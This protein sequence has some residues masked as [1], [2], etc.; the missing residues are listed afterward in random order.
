M[1]DEPKPSGVLAE[2]HDLD[3]AIYQAVAATPTPK[4]DAALH[5]LT[6]FADNSKL[7]F[8]TA[9]AIAA[10]G[11]RTG[12]RA[13]LNGVAAIGLASLVTNQGFKRAHRR[14]RPDR[15]VAAVPQMRRVPMPTS[16]SFPS[17]HSASA[18]AF[19]EGVAHTVPWLG[20]PLRLAATTVA[21]TRVHAGVHYPGDVVAGS[22]IGLAC[23]QIAPHVVD[24][25]ADRVA[26]DT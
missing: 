12:R 19:A 25:V 2:L 17:G 16:T 18:F 5:G 15:E 23:G 21:Y 13:A 1:D 9:A 3:T 4:L 20:I 8:V 14:P 11:G 7:W 24:R 22:L 10:V 6:G 26:A